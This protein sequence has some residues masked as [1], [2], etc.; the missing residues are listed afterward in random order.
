MINEFTLHPKPT[1]I[2]AKI[3]FLVSLSVFAFLTVTYMVMDLYK[4]VIG[5]GAMVFLTVAIMFYTRYISAEYYYEVLF[6]NGVPMFIVKQRVGKRVTTLSSVALSDIREVL[7]Q[8]S[9]QRRQHKCEVGYRKYFYSPTLSPE[10]TLLLK[11]SS[12]YEKSE[13]RIEGTPELAKTLEEYANEARLLSA[14]D[15]E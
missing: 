8:N 5:L 4:G 6:A 15:E 12:R 1:N 14:D 13:I 11:V 3:A 9:Q 2:N 10:T 7:V